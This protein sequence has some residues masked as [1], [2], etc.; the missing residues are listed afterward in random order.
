M[1]K[2]VTILLFGSNQN[3]DSN[4]EVTLFVIQ[5]LKIA[6]SQAVLLMQ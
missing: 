2:T 1:T 6:Q 3:S 4:L 5:P